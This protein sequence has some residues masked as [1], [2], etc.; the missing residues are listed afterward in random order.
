M[1][2]SLWQAQGINKEEKTLIPICHGLTCQYKEWNTKVNT[3]L[4][5]LRGAMKE[6]WKHSSF[7]HFSSGPGETFLHSV[8]TSATWDSSVR[9]WIIISRLSRAHL[10][11]MSSVRITGPSWAC[12]A[13]LGMPF[14]HF[15]LHMSKSCSFLQALFKFLY[16]GCSHSWTPYLGESAC[17]P[18]MSHGIWF[19][20]L[21]RAL[22]TLCLVL[23]S[24]LYIHPRPYLLILTLKAWI[25]CIIVFQIGPCT[26][27]TFV[28][29]N[30]QC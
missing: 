28:E 4:W 27:N 18:L 1:F 26:V 20:V 8:S 7:C 12:P 13:S 6:L 15:N 29:S 5:N 3:Q 2:L 22:F 14:S 30:P 23:C 10:T 21:F 11:S 9:P 16:P 17:S 25:L 24:Y 19:T